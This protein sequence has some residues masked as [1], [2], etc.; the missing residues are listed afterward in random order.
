MINADLFVPQSRPRLFVIGVRA[1]VEID[2][3][4]LSPE[5]LVFFH[6]RGIWSRRG[7]PCPSP[8]GA[9]AMVE[10]PHTRP[11]GQHLAQEIEEHP[12]SVTW[13]TPAETEQLLAKMSPS[14]KPR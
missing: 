12:T 9:D 11:P 13:H 5:P 6:T 2:P 3:A 7:S 1:D 10:R 8:A 14:T 4:L